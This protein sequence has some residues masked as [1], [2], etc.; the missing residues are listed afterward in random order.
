MIYSLKPQTVKGKL[1]S[2]NQCGIAEVKPA[3]CLVGGSVKASMTHVTGH[4]TNTRLPV[5]IKG[6]S[7]FLNYGYIRVVFV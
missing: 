2:G 1:T 5:D 7:C 4:A 6:R 3:N